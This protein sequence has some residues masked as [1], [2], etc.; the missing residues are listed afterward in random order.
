MSKVNFDENEKLQYIHNFELG[1]EEYSMFYSGASTY[2]ETSDI[3]YESSNYYKLTCGEIA[4]LCI[5]SQNRGLFLPLDRD[6]MLK[7]G[8]SFREISF[9]LD[10]STPSVKKGLINME[11]ILNRLGFYQS[12]RSIFF[13]FMMKWGDKLQFQKGPFEWK[14][15]KQLFS[16]SVLWIN[17]LERAIEIFA[18]QNRISLQKSKDK[19]AKILA[20]SGITAKILITFLVGG[21][22]MKKL[23][24]ILGS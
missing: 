13:K 9:S 8:N 2:G 4:I 10:S 1:E 24:S 12:F 11:V 21:Q 17:L 16:N 20:D 19:I 15:F 3:S 18:E 14:G 22:N 7:D 5:D 23:H 6:I